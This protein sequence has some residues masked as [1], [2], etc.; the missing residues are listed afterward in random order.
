MKA[1]IYE[2]ELG[3]KIDEEAIPEDMLETAKEWREKM[4]ESVAECDEDLMMKFLDGEELTE[5]RNQ[6]QRSENRRSQ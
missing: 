1:E 2:D 3:T 6:E 5:G 4:L